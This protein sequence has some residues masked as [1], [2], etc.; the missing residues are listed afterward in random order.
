MTVQPV[1][2][3]GELDLTLATKRF[4]RGAE[5]GGGPDLTDLVMATKPHGYEDSSP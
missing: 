2:V 1:A 5:A 3:G 4:H